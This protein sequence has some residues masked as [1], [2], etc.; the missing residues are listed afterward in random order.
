MK[1]SVIIPCFDEAQHVLQAIEAV[2]AVDIPKQII[3]VDDGSTDDT[4]QVLADYNS[5]GSI[6]VHRC[7]RNEGKGAAIRAG[8]EYVTGDVVI[9]QDAD[10]EYDPRQFP[11]IVKPIADGEADVVYGSRFL[12]SIEG[13]RLRNRIANYILAWTANILF[14]AHL[15]DEATC[16]KAFKTD[17]LKS[18]PLRCKRFE[19][20]PEV[21]AKVRKRGIKIKEV[22]IRYVGRCA[23]QGKKIKWTDA[24][25][26]M[27]A[28][29]KYRFVD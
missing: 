5:D 14:N 13:M 29:I 27:W 15:T 19:F 1:L 4:R 17:L 23:A 12:G 2:K 21:T 3:V 9:I 24:F 20:C 18:L 6:I 28:L 16:Y 10:L 25:E 22:P 11:E 8:L 26:A 7:E